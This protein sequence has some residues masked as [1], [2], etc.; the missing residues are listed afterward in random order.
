MLAAF[1]ETLSYEMEPFGVKIICFDVGHF[2][3]PVF[4]NMNFTVPVIEDYESMLADFGKMG[5]EL[6]GKQPGYVGIFFPL[7]LSSRVLTP[8]PVIPF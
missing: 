2:R 7:P 6:A 5:A 3:T 4:D 8:S 1:S